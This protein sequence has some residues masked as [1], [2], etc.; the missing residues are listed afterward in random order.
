MFEWVKQYN[1]SGAVGTL[2]GFVLVAWIQPT[3]TAGVGLLILSSI[4][5]CIVL[6]FL[7]RYFSNR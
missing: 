4:L 2:L 7:V 5:I 3:T 1:V 6:A